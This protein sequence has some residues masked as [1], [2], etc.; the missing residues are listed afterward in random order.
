MTDRET[1]TDA[2]GP[3]RR[4]VLKTL[5]AA[6]L[7]GAGVA[8]ASGSAAAQQGGGGFK[9]LSFDVTRSGEI[10]EETD[11]VDNFDVGDTATFDGELVFTDLAVDQNDAGD[12]VLVASGRLK[13]ELASNPTEQ[14]N[15]TFEDLVLGLLEDILD[16]LS[17]EEAGECPILELVVG[18][19]FLDLLGLQIETNRI[20]I[21]ITAVAGE[22]NLLGNLLC[23]VANLLNP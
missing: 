3:E 19:I 14:I 16:V 7:A 22:G 11:A 5:A 13:G 17:P 1:E 10:V 12:D 8:G 18:P 21:D 6:G 15:E 4:T 23:A 2:D 20:E 9:R